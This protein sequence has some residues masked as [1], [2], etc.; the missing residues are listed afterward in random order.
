MAVPAELVAERVTL[1]MP[2]AVGVPE[3]SPV[4]ALSVRPAGRPLAAKVPGSLEA[5]R[6]SLRAVPTT[7]VALASGVSTGGIW[8][9]TSSRF[10]APVPPA[11]AAPRTTV[12]VPD[13]RGI[14][15]MSRF[16]ELN[17]RP[18]G[19]PV[20]LKVVGLL[21]A[22]IWQVNVAPYVPVALTVPVNTGGKMA[23]GSTV[24]SSGAV[25]VPAAFVARS[26]PVKTPAVVNVPVIA[27]VETL[28]MSPGAKPSVL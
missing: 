17:S 6:F 19:S 13:C 20:A 15:L 11:F 3:I 1:E 25:P 4:R 22:E 9:M 21:V 14:P 8:A 23:G 18:W 24:I 7:A 10:A 12:N 16:K 28:R 26:V 5:E 2:L 27:P